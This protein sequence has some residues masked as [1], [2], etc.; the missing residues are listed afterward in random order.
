MT[1]KA[2]GSNLFITFNRQPSSV[3]SPQVSFS[4]SPGERCDGVHERFRLD[5]LAKVDLEAR[6]QRLSLV[7]FARVGGQSQRRKRGGDAVPG[8]PGAYLG[9]H[10]IPILLRHSYV[11]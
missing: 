5:W 6:V 2:E 1:E 11:A 4:A 8:F 10:G 9:E 7:G 3:F